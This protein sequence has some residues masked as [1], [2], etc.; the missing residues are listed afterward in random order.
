MAPAASSLLKGPLHR[1]PWALPVLR[2]VPPRWPPGHPL[3]T[4]PSL[5]DIVSHSLRSEFAVG[6]PPYIA[7][8]K[9][10]HDTPPTIIAAQQRCHGSPSGF[11]ALAAPTRTDIVVSSMAQ[12][13]DSPLV[14]VIATIHA[15]VAASQE[16]ERVAALAL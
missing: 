7:G 2:P 8:L 15:T 5:A 13:T 1:W 9:P 10:H 11:P 6:G 14:A 16:R 4:A 3:S 12:A